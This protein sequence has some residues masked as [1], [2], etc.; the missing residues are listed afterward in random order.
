MGKFAVLTLEGDLEQH[1]VHVSLGVANDEPFPELETTG[2]LPEMQFLDV[3][4]LY[5]A[6]KTLAK[7]LAV[8][9]SAEI[10]TKTATL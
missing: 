7:S 8:I 6:I 9:R 10:P 1:S 5:H 4:R 3:G 2:F